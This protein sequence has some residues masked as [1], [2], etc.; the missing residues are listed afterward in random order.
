MFFLKSLECDLVSHPGDLKFGGKV[1]RFI[2]TGVLL[3]LVFFVYSYL[4]KKL[5]TVSTISTNEENA[6]RYRDPR[7]KI[8]VLPI[9]L[10]KIK[11]N[12]IKKK[13]K[14]RLNL[15]GRKNGFTTRH[16][17]CKNRSRTLIE[18]MRLILQSLI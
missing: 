11:S 6:I 1:M 17:K 14:L 16:F 5:D 4:L 8:K 9:K 10:I 3:S 18:A 12:L 13:E 15:A 2:D 7:S